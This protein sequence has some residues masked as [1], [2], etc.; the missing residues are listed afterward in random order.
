MIGVEDVTVVPEQELP[1]GNFPTCPYPNPEIKQ[2]FECAINLSKTKKADLLVATD[3]DCDRLGIAVLDDGE[4]K[5]MTGNEV[6]AMF[7]EYLL[8]TLTE[9][10]RL[11]KDPVVVKTI[12]TSPLISAIAAAH[13]AT[14]ANLLTGFKYIGELVT[15]LESKNEVDRFVVGM[16]ESYGYLR[17]SHARDK[18]AV[19]ASMLV[20]EMASYYKLKGMSLYDFMQSI[21]KKYG[22]YLNTL[23]NFGFEG[24]AGM[25]K[26]AEMMDSLRADGLKN[27]AGM[28]VI[29][30]SDYEAGIETNLKTGEKAKI[31]LPKS[32]VLAYTLEGGNSVIVR[33]SGTE[34]KIKIYITAVGNTRDEAK[35]VTDKI[36]D[37]M[38]KILGI[39]N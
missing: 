30:S 31:T 32:N 36:S 19:V 35:T 17:G 28:N 37:D 15:K 11:P 14:T 26:M 18:D 34:P 23:L 22:L 12:V 39:K 10:S 9:Q 6:G 5:L 2:A 24:A 7:T 27:I 16:E 25:K 29:T 21:Y 38:E 8:E 33:P 3:P 20:C 13:G 1:D 4:Y